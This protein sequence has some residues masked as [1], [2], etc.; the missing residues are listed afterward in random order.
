MSS[1]DRTR[2]GVIARHAAALDAGAQSCQEG[3]M[4]PTARRI[5]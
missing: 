5:P 1:T 2:R 4:F 3:A